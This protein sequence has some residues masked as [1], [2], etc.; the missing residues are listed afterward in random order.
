MK[1]L[2]LLLLILLTTIKVTAQDFTNPKVLGDKAFRNK[3]YYEAAAYYKKAA[4]GLSLDK[5]A[6]IPYQS[7]QTRPN[8]K[9]SAPDRAYVCYS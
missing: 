3:N 1:T 5:K 9:I 4:E 2:Y 8:Q 6:A 7:D